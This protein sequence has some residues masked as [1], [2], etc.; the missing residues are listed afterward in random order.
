[1]PSRSFLTN[2]GITM[3][4]TCNNNLDQIVP[5]KYLYAKLIL[6]D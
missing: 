3:I 1:M 6:L 5:V 2:S 4:E